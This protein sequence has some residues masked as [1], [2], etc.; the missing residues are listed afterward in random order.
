MFFATI[1][2]G[3]QLAEQLVAVIRG[4]DL[5][6]WRTLLFLYLVVCL[7]VRMAPPSQRTSRPSRHEEM[8]I[9]TGAASCQR[10]AVSMV[11]G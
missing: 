5:T 9:R 8:P 7:T 4:C 11:R 3:L 1:Q 10:G 6:D 2:R